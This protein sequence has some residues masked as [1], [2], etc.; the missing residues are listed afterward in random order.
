MTTRLNPYLSFR[1]NARQAMDFYQSVFGGELTRATFA[2]FQ[3]SE[4]PA[5]QDKVMHSMLATDNGLQTIALVGEVPLARLWHA[6]PAYPTMSEVWL[7]LL[8]A[9][10]AG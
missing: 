1:D 9:Y 10:R 3:A 2:E 7:R 4:D 6:V 5:E 8:E